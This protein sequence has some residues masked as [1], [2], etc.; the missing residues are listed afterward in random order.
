MGAEHS[1]LHDRVVTRIS[2]LVESHVDVGADLPLGAHGA[3]GSHANRIAVAVRLEGDAVGVD[4]GVGK[5]KHLEAARVRKGGF[6]PVGEF[7]DAAGLSDKLG[8]W[9]KEKVI[10]V[11]ENGGGFDSFEV[12]VGESLDGGASG[13]ADKSGR[14]DF[15]VSGLDDAGAH[16]RAFLRGGCGGLG[17]FGVEV[18]FERLLF[19]SKE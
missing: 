16:K 11:D 6:L 3:F 5:G 4:F 14:L 10:G 7:V 17:D 12:A 18:G 1:L 19:N 8:A 13:G 15:A 2:G 9:G